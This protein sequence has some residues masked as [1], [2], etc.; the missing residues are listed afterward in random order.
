MQLL[1]YSI[2]QQIHHHLIRSDPISNPSAFTVPLARPAA[3]PP[4]SRAISYT[5]RARESHST[6]LLAWWHW[7]LQS[8]PGPGLEDSHSHCLLRRRGS[9][10]TDIQHSLSNNPTQ[11]LLQQWRPPSSNQ[12]APSLPPRSP[13]STPSPKPLKPSVRS[14][15]I[16]ILHPPL[17]KLHQANQ[18][19]QTNVSS[20][21]QPAATP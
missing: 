16:P 12:T 13:P 8:E 21:H 6:C 5:E 7:S 14:L 19:T 2:D 1:H 4:T 10:H 9:L 17:T 20:S 3:I 11:N 15:T 18:D